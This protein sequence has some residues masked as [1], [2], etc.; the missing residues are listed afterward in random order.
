M[1]K[2]CLLDNEVT[3][4]MM[5]ALRLEKVICRL[6]LS[7]IN[8][9]LI[10]R[11]PDRFSGLLSLSESSSILFWLMMGRSLAARAPGPVDC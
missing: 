5:P 9:I 1:D 3:F 10:L 4:F 6:D 7:S 11:L 2:M 8:S